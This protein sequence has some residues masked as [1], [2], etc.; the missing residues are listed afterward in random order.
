MKVE[1]DII[2]EKNLLY[3]V[4]IMKRKWLALLAAGLS[5]LTV[6]SFAACSTNEGS[7]PE[8]SKT[9]KEQVLEFM[10]S[11]NS[12]EVTGTNVYAT[13]YDDMVTY[14]KEQH[15]IDTT[16]T[17]IDINATA[18]YVKKYD[19]TY[20]EVV[21]VADKA[22]DYNDV[23]L[24]WWDLSN[25]SEYTDT[26]TSMKN[27]SGNIVISGGQYSL[28][29]TAYSGCYAIAFK[30]VVEVDR[31]LAYDAE[32]DADWAAYQ[33]RR[34]E[35][36]NKAKA[37]YSSQLDVFN[38]IDNTPTS[39]DY[40]TSMTD[41]STRLQK[42][43]LITVQQLG[44]PTDLNKVYTFGTDNSSYVVL[45]TTAYQFGDITVYFFDTSD[46]YFSY[47]TY[48]YM[49]SN[50]KESKTTEVYYGSSGWYV[51]GQVYKYNADKAYD[52]NGTTLTYSVD[53]IYGNFAIS[54]AEEA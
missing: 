44:N 18:G 45:A 30:S 20:E 19:A 10:D 12:I 38:S 26:Y 14:L 48:S 39:I 8:E 1:N 15:V 27:N 4:Y 36:L 24:F 47:Y 40:F 23:W 52:E 3:E 34:T 49:L 31:S 7:S 50:L 54:V 21:K 9:R 43:G 41:L 42:A 16:A 25:N 13:S 2:F 32:V 37:D 22:Y 53:A 11:L 35:A 28:P 6:L 29:T 46:S 51:A 17:G 5:A 33:T